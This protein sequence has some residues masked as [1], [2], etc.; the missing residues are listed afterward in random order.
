MSEILN[1]P[2]Q[3]QYPQV[4]LNLAFNSQ[5]FLHVIVPAKQGTKRQ[6]HP[7]I[8]FVT[9]KAA[10]G[11]ANLHLKPLMDLA[12]HG[13]T[14]AIIPAEQLHGMAQEQVVQLKTAIRYL[15]LHAYQYDIDTNRCFLWGEKQ[16]ALLSAL[17]ILT[18]NV[19][20]WNAEDA[21]VLPLRFKGGIL[22]GLS[23]SETLLAQ[24]PQHKCAP[25]FIFNGEDD[26]QTN[27]VALENFTEAFK[28]QHHEIQ[29]TTLQKTVNGT[30]AFYTPYVLTILENIFTKYAKH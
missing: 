6:Y 10:V 30:D 12:S 21:R 28:Q 4:K 26:V 24:I 5:Q 11:Q 20:E 17:C 14:I 3:E 7:L 27:T 9:E 16:G 8:V 22:F 19:Q 29:I 23:E 15:M 25:L 2:A 18:A 13:F 1:E